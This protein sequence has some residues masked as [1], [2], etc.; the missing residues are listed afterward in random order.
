MNG[1]LDMASKHKVKGGRAPLTKLSPCGEHCPSWS[2]ASVLCGC[3]FQVKSGQLALVMTYCTK[4]VYNKSW[5]IGGNG[6]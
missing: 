3:D 5:R 1:H 4:Y 6:V 2:W